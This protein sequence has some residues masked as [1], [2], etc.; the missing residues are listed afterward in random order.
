MA[1]AEAIEAL[2]YGCSTRALYQEHFS[3]LRTVHHRVFLRTIGA[4]C[5]KPD[6]PMASCNRALEMT[7]YEN[8]ES[9]RE[10]FYGWRRL[11]E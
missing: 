3:K 2:L 8:I 1:K 4:Q 9:A 6:H 10:D 5:K 11:S 7:G